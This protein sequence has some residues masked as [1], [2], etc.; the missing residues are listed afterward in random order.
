MTERKHELKVFFLEDNPDDVELE[1]YEIRRGGFDVTFEVAM[2][3]KE[4]LEKL[5]SIDADIILAD[6]SLPDITGIDAIHICQEKKIDVPI[7]FITGAG[8]E[9]IAVDS[10]R[11]GAIDYILKKNIMGLPGRVSRA[12]EIWTEHKAKE[13]AEKERE[14][15][16]QMLFQS[17]KMESVGRLASGVAHEFNNII[18]GLLGFAEIILADT[19]E[20]SSSYKRLQTI[21][22]LCKRGAALTRQLLIF[23]RRAPV[24]FKRTSINSIIKDTLNLI[25]HTVKEG[26]EIRLNLQDGTPEIEADTGQLTQVLMNLALNA[27]DAMEGKGILEFRTERCSN[28]KYA[29]KK[30]EYVCISVSDTGC[31]IPED[32][33]PKI[34]EPFFTT[35]EM[36]KG[37]GLGLAT[38]YSI[39]NTHRGWIDVHSELGKGTT[40][41]IYLPGIHDEKSAQEKF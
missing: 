15:F 20:D 35:K 28:V 39:V 3:R 1:L 17:Q 25:G 12:L 34:F 4:F 30:G 29:D 6:Y 26:I 22:T 32:D 27:K 24:E 33:I 21:I 10:L 13:R 40:F 18:T 9:Q 11:E 31:G 5:P 8:N 16:Q 38:V 14:Q 19:P 37:V 2:N 7:I 23:G 41:K 36:G